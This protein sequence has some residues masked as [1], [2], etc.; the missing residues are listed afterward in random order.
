M[1]TPILR[2]VRT[3]NGDYA[4]NVR[5]TL[6]TEVRELDANNLDAVIGYTTPTPAETALTADETNLL[7]DLT[8]LAFNNAGTALSLAEKRPAQILPVRGQF[9]TLLNTAT[10][11]VQSSIVNNALSEVDRLR[12]R[13]ET[14][15]KA[16]ES[17]ASHTTVEYQQNNYPLATMFAS[18]V[19]SVEKGQELSGPSAGSYLDPSTGKQYIPF[20]KTTKVTSPENFMYSV[21]IFVT[22]ICQIKREA[23]FVYFALTKEMKRACLFKGH[24]AGQAYMDAFLRAL[25]QGVFSNPVALVAAGE[26]NRIFEETIG[27]LTKVPTEDRTKDPLDPRKKIKF[28]PVTTPIGGAGAGIITNWTTGQKMKC[29]RFHANPKQACT[30]GVPAGDPRFKPEQVGLC[31]YAH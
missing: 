14:K 3:A 8:T 11:A 25:D 30:A 27:H 17:G 12:A 21:M 6:P 26:H 29:T 2:D 15:I 9:L 28:G 5:T 20:E 24:V 1:F 18:I 22:S 31:A 4:H 13:Q 7:N 10:T 16:G 23:P 19:K